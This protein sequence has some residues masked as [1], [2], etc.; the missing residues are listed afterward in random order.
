MARPARRGFSG[1]SR[2]SS[3][4]FALHLHV[5]QQLGKVLEGLLIDLAAVVVLPGAAEQ[6]LR[7]KLIE[8]DQRGAVIG[9][10]FTAVAGVL[11]GDPHQSYSLALQGGFDLMTQI[12]LR[13]VEAHPHFQPL[14]ALE[15]FQQINVWQVGQLQE[16]FRQWRSADALQID[17]PR[18]QYRFD[19]DQGLAIE[20]DV[21]NLM[22]IVDLG[23][24]QRN[25]RAAVANAFLTVDLLRLVQVT[26][27]HIAD[28]WPEQAGG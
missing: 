18:D 13:L 20:G 22:L 17:R 5:L 7:R 4:L 11:G 3:W 28:A 21:E 23:E 9:A 25:R 6:F 27:G 12:R 19:A 26:E 24:R 14:L 15:V 8:F 10:I 2:G 16:D 1:G